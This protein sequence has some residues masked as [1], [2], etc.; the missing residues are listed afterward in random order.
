MRER[1]SATL[2]N[3]AT[4]NTVDIRPREEFKRKM[5][6]DP[7]GLM[8][9]IQRRIDVL[10]DEARRKTVRLEIIPPEKRGLVLKMGLA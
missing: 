6:E 7:K 10:A 2:I 1:K 5:R 8:E 4:I 9:E 3:S